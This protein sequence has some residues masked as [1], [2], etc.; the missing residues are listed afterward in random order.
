MEKE[1]VT[2]IG[3]MGMGVNTLGR[4]YPVV[5]WLHKEVRARYMY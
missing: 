4:V 3:Y 5:Q 2:G 1:E